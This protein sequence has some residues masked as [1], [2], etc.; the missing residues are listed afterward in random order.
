M[1]GLYLTTVVCSHGNQIQ[2]QTLNNSNH[3]FILKLVFRSVTDGCSHYNTVIVA[4]YNASQIILQYSLAAHRPESDYAEVDE[5][6]TASVS[7]KSSSVTSPPT[8]NKTR[9]HQY[10]DIDL[11]PSAKEP[12][13]AVSSSPPLVPAKKPSLYNSSIKVNLQPKLE[14]ENGGEGVGKASDAKKNARLRR[15]DYSDID[16]PEMPKAQE[17]SGRTSLT[18]QEPS[19][20]VVESDPVS[21]KE[22]ERSDNLLF[23]VCVCGLEF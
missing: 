14:A 20:E 16:L 23:R 22:N 1:R 21:S 11:Q 7:I 5:L 6:E 9:T 12:N 13:N 10:S 19:R 15:N 8:R 2:Y 18:G 3:G 4:F 17:D